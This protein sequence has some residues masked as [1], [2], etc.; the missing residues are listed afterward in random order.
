M[1][2]GPMTEMR[3]YRH[4]VTGLISIL[5]EDQASVFPDYLEPVA[6]DAKPYAPGLFKPGKVGEFKNPEPPTEAQS[7]ARKSYEA[8]ALDNAANSKVVRDAKAAVEAA[9]AEAEENRLAAIEAD[10]VAE[11][12]RLDLEREAAVA[13]E[14]AGDQS[15]DQAGQ[16]GDP[17]S[18]GK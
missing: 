14:L 10:R 3:T 9:D 5:T 2:Y 7:E 13:A 16:T 8:L 6:D 12:E 17:A 1:Y 18:E 4:S 15:G 11:E